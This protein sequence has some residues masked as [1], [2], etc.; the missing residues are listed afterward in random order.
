M[1]QDPHDSSHQQGRQ[2]RVLRLC[3]VP[4]LQGDAADR[5]RPETGPGSVGEHG[6]RPRQGQ[7]QRPRDLFT[8]AQTCARAGST[9]PGSDF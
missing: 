2:E 8:R 1:V 4:C 5:V 6:D 7:E 3:S 9:G